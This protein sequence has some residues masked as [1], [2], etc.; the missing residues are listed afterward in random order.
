VT[1]GHQALDR[2]HIPHHRRTLRSA[3]QNTLVFLLLTLIL[4]KALRAPIMPVLQTTIILLIPSNHHIRRRWNQRISLVLSNP[5][6]S[7]TIA[8]IS[9]EMGVRTLNPLSRLY[10]RSTALMKPGMRTP[11]LGISLRRLLFGPGP[12]TPRMITST[13]KTDHRN[14]STSPF[15]SSNLNL[16]TGTARASGKRSL[17]YQTLKASPVRANTRPPRLSTRENRRHPR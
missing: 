12:R 2:V 15:N 6:P 3:H 7:G 11:L 10:S 4:R 8:H 1:T 13:Q 17:S 16:I 9:P 5:L 14:L